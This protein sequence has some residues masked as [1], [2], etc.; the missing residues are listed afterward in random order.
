M[1][2][3]IFEALAPTGVLRA[4]INMSNFLLVSGTLPDGT[5]DG[6]SPDIA[7]RIAKELGVE[8]NFVLFDRPG[9]L[10]DAVDANIWDIGNIA[11]EAARAHTIDFSIPYV[12]ID[13]NFLVHKD[14]R[15]TRNDDI[16]TDGT[17]IAVAERST[18]EIYLS[19]HFTNAEIIR[20]TS[21]P[22]SLSGFFLHKFGLQRQAL[23]QIWT[24]S[25][26]GTLKNPKCSG[27]MHN[28]TGSRGLSVYS[29][30]VTTKFL[31]SWYAQVEHRCWSVLILSTCSESRPSAQTAQKRSPYPPGMLD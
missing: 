10:A 28:V 24:N 7:R 31:G 20:T 19:D 21:I 26:A 13:A 4:G 5:P 29:R 8:C 30:Y 27:S 11:F 12:Q 15:F 22:E 25:S 17:K 14:S 18:Y 6:I 3:V 16:D 23:L 2:N 1:D 9:D